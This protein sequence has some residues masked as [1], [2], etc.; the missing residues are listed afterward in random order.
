MTPSRPMRIAKATVANLKDVTKLADEA[1]IWLAAKGTDQWQSA[2]PSDEKRDD[3]VRKGL[4]E[5]QTWIA[6]D[7]DVAVASVSI[8]TEHDPAVWSEPGCTCDLSE[9]AVYVHRLIIARSYAGRG[10]GAEL[11]DWAGLRASRDY[12][13]RWIRIDVWTTN[14]ALHEY[15][16]GVGF[17]RCGSCL[18]PA[19]PSAALFQKPITAITSPSAPQFGET[20]D[21]W[22]TARRGPG[23]IKPEQLATGNRETKV[24][25]GMARLYS[26]LSEQF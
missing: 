11:T 8:T 21:A 9:P 10:L 12:G 5:G 2:W 13:A 1:R 19:Y 6:W 16:L 17:E 15:Y 3:R 7:H 20:N 22:D 23:F 14:T 18:D 4:N 26:R 25:S 24:K